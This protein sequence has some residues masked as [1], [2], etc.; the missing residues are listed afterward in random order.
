M[1]D[2]VMM[3]SEFAVLQDG[4]A[5]DRVLPHQPRDLF[6]GAIIIHRDDLLAHHVFNL[7][8]V[9]HVGDLPDAQRRS[10]KTAGHRADLT[11]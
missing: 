6:D 10:P 8:L 2:S 5:A 1:S 7:D 3:P 11:G 4:H 9:E